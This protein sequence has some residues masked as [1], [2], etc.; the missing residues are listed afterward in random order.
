MKRN[1]E[2]ETHE[3][4]A[5]LN[6]GVDEVILKHK[7]NVGTG[8]SSFHRQDRGNRPVGSRHTRFGRS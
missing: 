4:T 8:N 7:V 2:K 5:G 3:I 1:V 6:S